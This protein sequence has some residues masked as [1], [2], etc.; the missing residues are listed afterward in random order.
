MINKF[1]IKYLVTAALAFAITSISAIADDSS[2]NEVSLTSLNSDFSKFKPAPS[3]ST[4]LDY[5]LMDEALGYI[6]L[7][8]GPSLRSRLPKPKPKTGTRFVHGHTSPYRMEGTRVTFDYITDGF[9]EGL[10]E[11]RK[12]LERIGTRVDIAKL[13]RNEQLAYWFNLHNVTVLEQL[14]LAY[15]IE[16]PRRIKVAM[17]GVRTPLDKAKILNVKDQA[18]SLHDIRENIVFPN[19]RDPVVFYGFYRGEIGSPKLHR[20]AFNASNL[21]FFLQ[22][23]AAEFVNSLRG[24]RAANRKRYVSKLYGEMQD[25][26]FT[27]FNQDLTAHLTKYAKEDLVAEINTDRPIVFDQ[28][29]DDISDLSNGHRRGSS[30]LALSGELSV[31]AEIEQFMRESIEKQRT[32]ISRGLITPRGGYVIIEDVIVED[33]EEP[34]E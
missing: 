23:S 24:F 5:S 32:L 8:L 11:Y 22:E 30:G 15:P 2:S 7:D 31:S 17:D 16:E 33:D 28:Y 19:W 29:Q 25:Q 14:S 34:V 3:K 18:L 27:D 20:S 12:E 4:R 10:T 6:V 26:F 21:D 13:S 9:L 1:F